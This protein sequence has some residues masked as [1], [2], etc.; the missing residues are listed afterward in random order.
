MRMKKNSKLPRDGNENGE[1]KNVR[2]GNFAKSN[3]ISVDTIRYYIQLKLIHPLRQGK[4]FYFGIEQQE[5][6]DRIIYYK[7]LRFS[8]DEIKILMN[9]DKLSILETPVKS[10]Y[11]EKMI[12]EKMDK[13]QEEKMQLEDIISKLKYEIDAVKQ[14]PNLNTEEKG[15]TFSQLEKLF[16]PSCQNRMTIV[17]GVLKNHSVYSGRIVCSCGVSMAIKEGIIL[18]SDTVEEK[19]H[20]TE[21][22]DPINT[23]Y[24]STSYTFIQQM[25]YFVEEITR[26]IKSQSISSKTVLFM[27]TGVGTLALNLLRKCPEVG[28]LILFDEDLEQLKVAKKT[29]DEHFADKNVLY[30]EGSFDILP[31]EKESVDLAIDF[32]ASFEA[33]LQGSKNL[34][35]NLISY[36]KSNS[37]IIGLYFYY[38]KKSTLAKLNGEHGKLLDGAS[39][40]NYLQQKGYRLVDSYEEQ[41]LELGKYIEKFHQNEDEAFAYIE[42]YDK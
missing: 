34:Y 16:C 10:N 27:K 37:M 31:I 41:R 8:L 20:H 21:D 11:I 30:I 35:H 36:M 32:T 26:Y 6:I 40:R 38:K 4:Y 3:D 33:A 5:Q 17:E 18:T 19:I 15:I 1:C 14:T 13:L 9:T 29:I 24:E 39:F 22:K 25:L 12:N 2:I 42:V 7:G 23:L 28:M